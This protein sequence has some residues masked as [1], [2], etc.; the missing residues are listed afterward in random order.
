ML[1][2]LFGPKFPS[3]S[4]CRMAALRVLLVSFGLLLTGSIAVAQES[5]GAIAG[6]VKDSSGAVLPGVTVEASSPALIEKSRSTTTDQSGAYRIVDLYPGEY[7][8][9][10]TLSGFR[11]ITQNG[12]VLTQGFTAPVNPVLQ[13]G[14]VEQSVTVTAASPQIDVQST[15]ETD[16]ILRST[17]TD[18]PTFESYVAVGQLIPGNSPPAG[19]Q[20]VGGSSFVASARMTIH[21]GTGTDMQIM[22]DGLDI[23]SLATGGPGTTGALPPEGE[24]ESMNVQVG[25]EP[26]DIEANGSATNIIPRTGGDQFHGGIYFNF[27]NGALQSSNLTPALQSLGLASTTRIKE[28][29]SIAPSIGG[30]IIKGK[31]WFFFAG[32]HTVAQNYVANDYFNASTNPFFYTADLNRPGLNDHHSDG[33]NIRLTYQLSPKNR[34]NVYWEYSFLCDCHLGLSGVES[35]E[36]ANRVDQR[37]HNL[38]A[39]WTSVLSPKLLFTF[40]YG[41][42]ATVPFIFGVQPEGTIPVTDSSLGFSWGGAQNGYSY[43]W[44]NSWDNDF[45]GS[46][47]Y[48]TGE[49]ALQFGA[50][51]KY[52]AQSNFQAHLPLGPISYTLKNGAPS[53]VT[54]YPGPENMTEHVLPNLGIYGEDKW[55]IKSHLTLNLGLRFD[56]LRTTY[57]AATDPVSSYRPVAFSTTGG[58]VLNWKDLDPRLGAVYDVFHNGKTALKVNYSRYVEQQALVLTSSLNPSIA[59]QAS[60]TRT[61]NPPPGTIGTSSTAPAADPL[62]GANPLNP[63]PN[64]NNG[65]TCNTTTGA[66]CILGKSNN[67]AFGSPTIPLATTI[68]PSFAD[69]FDVRPYEWEFMAGVQQQLRPGIALSATFVRRSYGNI[70][71]TDNQAADSP[72]DWSPY[73]V[74][75]PSDSRLPGGGGYQVCGL[76]DINSAFFGLPAKN[77]ISSASKFGTDTNVWRGFDFLI[78]MRLHGIYVNGGLDTGTTITNN[79]AIVAKIGNPSPLYCSQ[80][81]P[82][83]NSFRMNGVYPLPLKFEVSAAFQSNPGPV[84]TAAGTFSN[85]QILGSLGHNLSEGVNAT[86]TVALVKPGSLYNNRANQLDFRVAKK[87]IIKERFHLEGDLDLYNVFNAVPPLTQN[88]TYGTNGANWLKPAILLQPRLVKFGIRAEF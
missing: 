28:L 58:T 39:T 13:V 50:E 82:Y 2:N 64:G 55:T 43:T 65:G 10:F 6:I 52:E 77:V 33:A 16:A 88:N 20:D 72:A 18:V 40:G 69:G 19:S 38:Q 61:W 81:T 1:S 73:C 36:V 74:T 53:S 54:I 78:D 67:A 76:Y 48:T 12:I 23:T 75:A 9:K 25:S 7:S 60:E 14:T 24:I 27:A 34:L 21:G 59:S 42:E 11:S 70:Q 83:L 26:A 62:A 84:I 47:S 56:I 85:A 44:M 68:D 32:E 45:K 8:I 87:F 22:L 46:L 86:Q 3:N 30:P 37:Y 31:L 66:N 29:Y 63:L 41:R 49:H 15:T 79:C 4:R 51:M 71:V 80:Q 17:I 5:A 35:P 57:G